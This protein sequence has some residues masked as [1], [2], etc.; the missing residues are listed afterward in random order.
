MPPKIRNGYRCT[1]GTLIVFSE[2]ELESLD[3]FDE[4][5]NRRQHSGWTEMVT[6]AECLGGCG[7]SIWLK[8]DDILV[9]ADRSEQ[10]QGKQ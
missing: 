5:R 1:C 8:A 9:L 2:T 7:E 10:V 3:A 4:L 6:H